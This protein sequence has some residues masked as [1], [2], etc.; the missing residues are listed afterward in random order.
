ME[1]SAALRIEVLARHLELAETVARWHWEEW[2][3]LTPTPSLDARVAGVRA[4][5]ASTFVTLY[6]GEAVGTAGLVEHDMDTQ[7]DLGPWLAG[8]DTLYLYTEAA[9]AFWERLGWY[10]IADEQYLGVTVSMMCLD[11][12]RAG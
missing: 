2:G 10:R 7:P 3:H 12:Q 11:L 1:R 9:Q 6:D 8:A 5:A 4:Q